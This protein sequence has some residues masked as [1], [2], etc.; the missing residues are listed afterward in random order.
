MN[1]IGSSNFFLARIHCFNYAFL[2]VCLMTVY[3]KAPFLT[4]G[5]GARG[6]SALPLLDANGLLKNPPC[7]CA[8]WQDVIMP[9]LVGTREPFSFCL[10]DLAYLTAGHSALLSFALRVFQWPLEWE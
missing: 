9:A 7:S 3:S 10:F 8:S 1:D 2:H 6:R 4:F 5:N